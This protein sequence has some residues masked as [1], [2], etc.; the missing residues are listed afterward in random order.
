M[1]CPCDLHGSVH[2]TLGPQQKCVYS[3]SIVARGNRRRLCDR[4]RGADDARKE[5]K[6]C[7][8]VD[9]QILNNIP[10]PP[11]RW[12]GE[13]F[14]L[15]P[16]LNSAS[17]ADQS[18]PMCCPSLQ[19]LWASLL[20]FADSATPVRETDI[21]DFGSVVREKQENKYNSDILKLENSNNRHFS[22]FQQNKRKYILSEGNETRADRGERWK[23]WARRQ[24]E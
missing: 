20:S 7:R 17:L 2:G 21:H 24:F 11:R 9:E 5:I 15:L 19:I 6:Y 16:P 22:S 12:N 18:D 4:G 14:F 10:S 8:L 1:G 13:D 3:G 23:E